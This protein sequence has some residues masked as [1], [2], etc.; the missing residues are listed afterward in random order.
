MESAIN[1]ILNMPWNQQSIWWIDNLIGKERIETLLL[2]TLVDSLHDDMIH[3]SKLWPK[4]ALN[5]HWLCKT[6]GW[7][8]GLLIK[9]GCILGDMIGCS[10][11]KIVVGLYYL[12][13]NNLSSFVCWENMV[14]FI[15]LLK[16]LLYPEFLLCHALSC[17]CS[18]KV[19]VM[20]SCNCGW[21][22]WSTWLAMIASIL[23]DT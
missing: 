20:S 17:I 10:R 18:C 22:S 7:N 23:V 3:R 2:T 8:Q 14:S 6:Y 4:S 19:R 1:H 13:A 11:I 21:L 9:V 5:E 16:Q 12:L 15:S